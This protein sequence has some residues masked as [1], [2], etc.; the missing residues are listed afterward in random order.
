[1]VR[2][3]K[4]FRAFAGETVIVPMAFSRRDYFEEIVRGMRAFDDRLKI[5]C[6]KAGM[7]TVLKRLEQRGEKI[8]GGENNWVVRKARECIE[9]HSGADFGEPVNT[10]GVSAVEV[11]DDILRRLANTNTLAK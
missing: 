3:T 5:F 9:A 11:A 8:D 4:I 6:L 10:E 7:P 1:V 2:G